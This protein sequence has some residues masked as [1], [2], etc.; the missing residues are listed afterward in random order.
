VYRAE[1]VLCKKINSNI[2]PKKKQIQEKKKFVN[3]ACRGGGPQR[4]DRALPMYE[5]NV[6]F[7]M[8]VG[9]DDSDQPSQS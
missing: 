3:F 9:A 6:P 5:R 2:D 8:M 1:R 7:Q 4:R